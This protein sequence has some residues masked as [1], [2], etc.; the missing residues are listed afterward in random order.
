MKKRGLLFICLLLLLSFAPTAQAAKH[1]T[2]DEGLTEAAEKIGGSA[3][4]APQANLAVVGFVESTRRTRLPLSSVLEDDLTSFLTEKRPGHVVAKNNIDTVLREL[5][6]TRDDLFDSRHRKQFGKLAS[7]D[8]LVSGNYW[9]NRRDVVINI[10][11]IDIESGL[12]LLS[13][14]VKIRKS[15]FAKYLLGMD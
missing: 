11:V 14:R 8:L 5:R 10:T 6:I 4:I 9:I 3:R 2:L 13:H 1:F 7:A 15:Q 12:A